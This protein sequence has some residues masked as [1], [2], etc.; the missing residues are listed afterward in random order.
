MDQAAPRPVATPAAAAEPVRPAVNKP[1]PPPPI[2]AGVPVPVSRSGTNPLPILAVIAL[3]LM[4]GI[5]TMLW[6]RPKSTEEQP[7]PQTTNPPATSTPPAQTQG[8]QPATAEPASAAAAATSQPAAAEPPPVTETPASP[9]LRSVA[10]DI[11]PWARVRVRPAEG[12]TLAVPPDAMY[13]PFTVDLAPGD[14]VL[15]CENG[16]INGTTTFQMKVD[17][18]EGRTQFFVRNMQG[19]NATKIVDALLG[20]Y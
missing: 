12:Q 6:L 18:A 15:E 17:A 1:L 16:G 13:S 4:L 2:A 7:P 5:G 14:Y 11:R 19:F 3:L 20:R 9:A 10:I 8:Q